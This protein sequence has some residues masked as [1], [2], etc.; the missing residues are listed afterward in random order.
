MPP[1]KLYV[2]FVHKKVFGWSIVPLSGPLDE[3]AI[4]LITLGL[5]ERL[6]WSKPVTIIAITILED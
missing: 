6:G 3:N 5:E 2:S 1:R 4:R